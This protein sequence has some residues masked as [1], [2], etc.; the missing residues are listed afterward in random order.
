MSIGDSRYPGGQLGSMK[1]RL[2]LHFA[3]RPWQSCLECF[4]KTDRESPAMRSLS[5]YFLFL[6]ATVGLASAQITKLPREYRRQL[7]NH[8][9][10]HEIGSIKDLPH[11]V[12]ALCADPQGKFADR[13]QPW[14]ATDAI[15]RRP[16]LPTNRLIWAASDG[17]CYVVHYECGGY[18]QRFDVLV[19]NLKANGQTLRFV[20]RREGPRFKNFIAF[21]HAI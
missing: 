16:M 15:V 6:L 18:V 10:F 14:Q 2:R 21:R 5:L 20:W 9:R 7:T 13:G 19:A 8:A 4:T 11:A 3:L 1:P 12:F 17:H